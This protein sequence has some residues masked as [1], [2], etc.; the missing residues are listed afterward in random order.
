MMATSLYWFNMKRITIHWLE[1]Y[2][3]YAKALPYFVLGCH[4]GYRWCHARLLS[5]HIVTRWGDRIHRHQVLDVHVD[6]K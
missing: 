3:N 2:L 4:L 5:H 1:I 6:G